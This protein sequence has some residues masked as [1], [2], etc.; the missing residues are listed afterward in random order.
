MNTLMGKHEVK[1]ATHA[2]KILFLGHTGFRFPVAHFATE[3]T[4]PSELY[5]IFWKTVKMGFLV[6]K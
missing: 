4:S 6:S 2:L 3:Q 5:L 1:L